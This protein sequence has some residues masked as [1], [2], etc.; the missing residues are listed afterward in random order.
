[1]IDGLRRF[2]PMR[3]STKLREYLED[4]ARDAN[5]GSSHVVGDKLE[6]ILGYPVGDNDPSSGD[7]PIERPER[8][9]K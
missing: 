5:D 3:M 6:R 1:M 8:W 9:E 7:G 2:T 4:C